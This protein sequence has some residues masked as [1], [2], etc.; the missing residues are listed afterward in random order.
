MHAYERCRDKFHIYTYLT[1][2]DSF[3]AR[4]GSCRRPLP[5]TKFC[6]TYDRWIMNSELYL[7]YHVLCIYEIKLDHN[8]HD[9]VLYCTGHVFT[10]N[11]AQRLCVF[12]GCK[13]QE[14][15]DSMM[16]EMQL[17]DSK[18]SS[19]SLAKT[20]LGWFHVSISGCYM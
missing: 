7:L 18:G 9:F 20:Q 11:L 5:E 3:D 12:D 6:R 1:H 16:S 4:K 15:L 19:A 2:L 13:F 17:P 14:Q 10:Y 8:K